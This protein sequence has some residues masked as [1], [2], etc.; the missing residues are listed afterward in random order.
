MIGATGLIGRAFMQS[1]V[2]RD[3][4]DLVAIARNETPLPHGAR[5]HLRLAQTDQW[6]DVIAEVQ[7]DVLVCALGSTWKKSGKDENTFRSVDHDLVIESARAAHDAGT[8]HMVT[9]SAV[10]ADAR[11]KSFYM[12]TKGEAEAALSK[13]GF[14]RLDILQPGLLRGARSN[15]RRAGE[16]AAIIASPLTDLMLQGKFRRFRSIADTE[17]ADA[18]LELALTKAAGRFT[19]DNDGIHRAAM[20]LR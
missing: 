3:D 1:C 16:R 9:V 4:I 13:V 20:R 14:K 2:G 8:T 18:A 12:R 5:M 17:V 10:G 11:S 7:P 6:R 15:D 19:H